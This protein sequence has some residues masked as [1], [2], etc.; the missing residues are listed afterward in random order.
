MGSGYRTKT[1]VYQNSQTLVNTLMQFINVSKSI[2][3]L[4]MGF[5]MS[6]VEATKMACDEPAFMN[7]LV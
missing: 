1:G 4:A 3:S 7:V 2:M 6:G 5:L